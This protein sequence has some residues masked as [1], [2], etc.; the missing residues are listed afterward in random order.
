MV[1][2][3]RMQ[4]GGSV[5][6]LAITD[7][8]EAATAGEDGECQAWTT[9]EESYDAASGAFVYR[10]RCDAGGDLLLVETRG[11]DDGLGNGQY[12]TTYDLRAGGQI[13]WSF[14]YTTED[15]GLTTNYAGSSTEGESMSGVYTVLE[16]GETQTSEVWNTLEGSYIVDGVYSEDGRFNGSSSFD[17]P[18]TEQSPDWTVVNLEGSDGSFSQD[19]SGVFDGWLS[20]YTY[21][22]AA[23]GSASYSF[24]HDELVTSVSPDFEGAY[25]YQADGSGEGHY[26]Q[27]FEDGSV[28][29]VTDAFE[30]DG[31]LT[32]S[33][34]L[35]DAATELEVDQRGTIHFDASGL[36]TGSVTFFAEDGSRETC[37]IRIDVDGTQTLSACS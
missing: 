1:P 21:S 17:D 31:S 19:V 7:E 6:T 28:M 8:E 4:K 23:D 9:E 10:Y 36:G 14:S 2:D 5:R 12:T 20:T 18:A 13:V 30:A 35:D 25:S 15:D 26:R 37:E 24:V 27:L 33:W 3:A 11:V 29:V 32:E 22:V 16:T 34:E